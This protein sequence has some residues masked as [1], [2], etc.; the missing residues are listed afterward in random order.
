MTRQHTVHLS[1]PPCFYFSS[2]RSYSELE[3]QGKSLC[4]D[5]ASRVNAREYSLRA[6]TRSSL[7]RT[8]RDAAEAMN[9]LGSRRGKTLR[10]AH[11]NPLSFARH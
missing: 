11:T 7:Y 8:G 2:C 6:P 1:P 10:L 3:K 4:R 9:L 5:C